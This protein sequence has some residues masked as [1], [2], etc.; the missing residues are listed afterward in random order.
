MKKYKVV[1]GMA[2]CYNPPV[3]P[4]IDGM[5]VGDT[6]LVWKSSC[7]DD[8]DCNLVCVQLNSGK[9]VEVNQSFARMHFKY[10]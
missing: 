5:N 10:V 1:V 8:M 2:T 9:V 3:A 4:H 6:L 7:V